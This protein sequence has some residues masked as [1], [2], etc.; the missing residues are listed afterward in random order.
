MWA[1]QR[2]VAN[3]RKWFKESS[4]KCCSGSL[5]CCFHCRG[6]I[7][8]Q[9]LRSPLCGDLCISRLVLTSVFIH[10]Q[11][12]SKASFFWVLVW[13]LCGS[14]LAEQA[15]EIIAVFNASLPQ[16]WQFFSNTNGRLRWNNIHT[17]QSK[18]DRQSGSFS[19]FSPSTPVKSLWCA[20]WVQML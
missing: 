19:F 5:C 15:K 13:T 17:L 16:H 4:N 3:N 7:W 2:A 14:H 12:L 10:H 9:D 6:N 18:P 20:V 8:E 1:Y 11:Q